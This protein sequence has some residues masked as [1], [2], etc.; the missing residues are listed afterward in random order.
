M[1]SKGKKMWGSESCYDF[2]SF[3]QAG[4]ECRS[5]VIEIFPLFLSSPGLVVQENVFCTCTLK[6]N[7]V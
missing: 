6:W 5:Q 7:Q 2:D 1:K 3:S 4:P